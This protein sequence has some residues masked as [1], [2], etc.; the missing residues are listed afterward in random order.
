MTTKVI[1]TIA[2]GTS[3][4]VI[5][6]TG[7]NAARGA[8]SSWS[9]IADSGASRVVAIRI[10]LCRNEATD[11]GTPVLGTRGEWSVRTTTGRPDGRGS[12]QAERERRLEVVA[13]VGA[14]RDVGLGGQDP[15]HLV[16]PVGHDVR[17][18]LVG[19][20]PDQHDEVD[21]AGDGVDLADAV[22]LGDRL[23]DLRDPGHVGLD[24]DD[25]GDHVP[26]LGHDGPVP[27]SWSPR[28]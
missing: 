6:V 21:L 4:R 14:E 7:E 13:R 28:S 2:S 26:T 9:W 17:D 10:S 27:T 23:A 15:G 16:E 19:L 11:A 25:R 18:V 20:D 3:T 22:E 24:E 8:S 5:S 12:L 1:S